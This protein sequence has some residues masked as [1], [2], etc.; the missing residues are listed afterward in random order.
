MRTAQ[1]L[2]RVAALR[3]APLAR[4]RRRRCASAVSFASPAMAATPLSRSCPIRIISVHLLDAA[5]QLLRVLFLDREGHICAQP[6]YV[7]RE[8]A[9]ILASNQQRVLGP[10]A[11]VRVL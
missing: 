7:P 4:R 1:G 3:F 2:T 6:H 9:L 10:Q 8:Q 11:E 5:G